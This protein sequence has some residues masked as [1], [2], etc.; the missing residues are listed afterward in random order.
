[1]TRPT[2]DADRERFLAAVVPQLAW[3]LG[4]DPPA[5]DEHVFRQLWEQAAQRAADAGRQLLLVVDGLDED[6]WPGGHSVAG[7][8]P[9]RLPGQPGCWPPA[10]CTPG[11]PTTSTRPTR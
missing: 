11:C 3:L 8:L 2:G 1:L 6:L 10:A 9:G 5:P 7:W 4:T